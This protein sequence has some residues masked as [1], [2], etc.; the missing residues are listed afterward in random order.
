MLHRMMPAGFQNVVEPDQI[1]LNVD[2]RMI[3]AV[4]HTGLCGQVHN[5]SRGVSAEDI[6][7]QRFVRN[8]TT[9]EDMLYRVN[10]A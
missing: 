10:A 4:A 2:I 6:L 5:H 1:A 3:N 9:D 7:N 8:G